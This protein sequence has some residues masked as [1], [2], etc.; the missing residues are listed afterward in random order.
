MEIRFGRSRGRIACVL[1][2][3]FSVLHSSYSQ[4]PQNLIDENDTVER[5]G[6][7]FSRVDNRAI[8]GTVA[9]RS[10]TGS[11]ERT[12][13]Y[14]GGVRHGL[15]RAYDREGNEVYREQW[16]AGTLDGP[17]FEF[18][19]GGAKKNER[20]FRDGTL[21]GE[22]REWYESG[23]LRVQGEFRSGRKVGTWKA[24]SESG[25]VVEIVT[26]AEGVIQSMFVTGEDIKISHQYFAEKL[27]ASSDAGEKA[28]SPLV[29]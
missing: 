11:L 7:L 29:P 27:K 10:W 26:F 2:V 1:V 9:S 18:F 13:D 20:S 12:I 28:F 22:Y 23:Q 4:A 16:R 8:E 24:F 21:D 14:R 15:F 17:A 25:E 6:L 5:D 19:K 3:L